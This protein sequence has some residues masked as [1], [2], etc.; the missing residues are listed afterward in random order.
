MKFN[1]LTHEDKLDIQNLVFECLEKVGGKNHFLGMIE[2]VKESS[3][4]P[5]MNKTGKYH[6]PSGTITWGKQIFKE[7]VFALKNM[8]IQHNDENILTIK[9]D[10]L[11]KDIQNTIKTLGNLEFLIES[12]EGD[13][14]TFKPFK[15]ISESNIEL[16]PI[17]QIIFF[18]SLNN[19]KKILDYK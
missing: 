10:K 3:Q 19:T 14:F 17:F 2:Q 6:F 9:N 16:D 5:L 13:E 7:K 8:L 4:H 12:K 11:Q 1:N 18:D 15:V